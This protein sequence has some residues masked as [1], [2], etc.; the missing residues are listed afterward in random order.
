[1]CLWSIGPVSFVAVLWEFHEFLLDYF[2][3]TAIQSSVADTMGDL[4]FGLVGGFIASIYMVYRL[5]HTHE[6]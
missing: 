6:K 1:M 5:G 3:H 2:F 4:F